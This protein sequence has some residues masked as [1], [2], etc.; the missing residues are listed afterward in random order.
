MLA[1]TVFPAAEAEPERVAFLPEPFCARA[2]PAAFLPEAVFAF[3]P[4]VFPAAEA[5]FLL[6]VPDAFFVFVCVISSSVMVRS[7]CVR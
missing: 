3:P 1:A 4:T 2:L 6:V 5:D 7:S